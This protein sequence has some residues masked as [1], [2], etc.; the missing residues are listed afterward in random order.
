MTKRGSSRGKRP[1]YIRKRRCLR[2]SRRETPGLRRERDVALCREKKQVCRAFDRSVGLIVH[3]RLRRR[4]DNEMGVC[5]ANSERTNARAHHVRLRW[6]W[7]K[8][9]YNLDRDLIPRD[10]RVG[11]I[12][13]KAW[14]KG[15]MLK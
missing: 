9:V 3:A 7:P 11:L 6:P 15:R 5:P 4:F 13:V 14:R 1:R 8:S 2:E 12:E 10:V